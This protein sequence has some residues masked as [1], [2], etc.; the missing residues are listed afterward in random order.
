MNPNDLVIL[1]IPGSLVALKLTLL[2]LAAVL[3]AKSIF[4]SH[5]RT[6]SV[7]NKAAPTPQR[8]RDSLA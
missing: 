6:I 1:A 8:L 7:R 2:A 4:K 3:A 5:R